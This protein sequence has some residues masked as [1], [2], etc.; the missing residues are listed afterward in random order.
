MKRCWEANE[1]VEYWTLSPAELALVGGKTGPNRL[2]FALLLKYFQIE[3]R[4][5]RHRYEVPSPAVTHV[6]AQLAVSAERYAHYD[7]EGRSVE[8]HRAQI[9]AWLGF[10]TATVADAQAL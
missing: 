10:R 5:P 1:L 7:W 6:A 9:R 2:G 4:F 3:G 8:Y